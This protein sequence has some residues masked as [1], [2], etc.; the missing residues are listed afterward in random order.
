MPPAV[1]PC[2]DLFLDVYTPVLSYN[3]VGLVTTPEKAVDP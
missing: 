1:Y 2:R 3:T